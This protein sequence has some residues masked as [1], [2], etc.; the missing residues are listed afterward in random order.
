VEANEIM[1]KGSV[2]RS[3]LAVTP[4]SDIRRE[5]YGWIVSLKSRVPSVKW[6]G[7]DNIHITLKFCGEMKMEKVLKLQLLLDETFDQNDLRN[8]NI[9]LG[10]PGA[11]PGMTK[12]R[13]LWIGIRDG[14]KELQFLASLI[15]RLCQ[16]VGIASE[17]RPFH[18][19]ITI[20]RVR[21]S[22]SNILSPVSMDMER[23]DFTDLQWDVSQVGHIRSTL[24]PAG[25]VYSILRS[26]DLEAL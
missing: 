5:I 25:P 9:V 8:F 3:F 21:S 4:P 2:I 11:F 16:K 24:L 15:D 19:H 26:Y 18:P 1:N 7:E 12:P 20:G 10:K 13:T 22:N 14:K 6:V 23:K 17:K